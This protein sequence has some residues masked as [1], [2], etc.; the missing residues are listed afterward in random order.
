MEKN[1]IQN[2]K[3]KESRSRTLGEDSVCVLCGLADPTILI[4]GSDQFFEEHHVVGRNHDPDL[5]IRICPNCHK[6]VGAGVA[7]SGASMKATPNI[8]DRMVHVLRTLGA[9]FR[10]LGES[11]QSWAQEIENEIKRLTGA[12]PD[13]REV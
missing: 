1:P 5:T 3:R 6:K 10:M 9:F 11:F 13:W 4:E 8:L 2:D 12:N 7:D